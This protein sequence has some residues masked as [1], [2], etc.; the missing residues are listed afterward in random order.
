[1]RRTL[2][3]IGVVVVLL[4]LQACG[5]R[6]VEE[7]QEAGGDTLAGGPG[8]V[9]SSKAPKAVVVETEFDFGEVDEG[10]VVEHVFKIRN[11]GS[12]DLAIL[13]ARGS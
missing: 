8:A 13:S 9:S 1:M 4:A 2:A 11:E 7:G 12:A 6:V 5:G 10:T 3:R